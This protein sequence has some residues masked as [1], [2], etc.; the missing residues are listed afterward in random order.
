M[1]QPNTPQNFE[2]QDVPHEFGNDD[3]LEIDDIVQQAKAQPNKLHRFLFI[4][5]ELTIELS[6]TTFLKIIYIIQTIAIC[7]VLSYF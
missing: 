1:I 4:Y 5:K 2:V 6:V 3:N 7:G